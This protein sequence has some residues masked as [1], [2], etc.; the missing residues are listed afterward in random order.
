MDNQEEKDEINSKEQ[1]EHGHNDSFDSYSEEDDEYFTEEEEEKDDDED[2]YEEEQQKAIKRKKAK[3]AKKT[4]HNVKPPSSKKT[5]DAKRCQ[6][7]NKQ[8]NQ[9]CRNLALLDYVGPNPLYCAE[10]IHL[11]ANSLLQKCSATC[12]PGSIP[13]QKVCK[14]IILKEVGICHKHMKDYLRHCDLY[15]YEKLGEQALI[16]TQKLLDRVNLV[17][18]QL[19]ADASSAKLNDRETFQRKAKLISKYRSIRSSLMGNLTFL[20]AQKK[21]NEAKHKEK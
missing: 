20:T 6:A 21:G 11:D 9:P 10:H 1:N 4:N 2:D 17:L 14:E 12:F 19:K 18:Q 8:K 16:N 7:V 5:S 13:K 3:K 15:S